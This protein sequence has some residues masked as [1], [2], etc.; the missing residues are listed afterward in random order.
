MYP[1]SCRHLENLI[2]EE[3]SFA[4]PR[5]GV[6][7]GSQSHVNHLL[8][9]LNQI[10]DMDAEDPEYR[11]KAGRWIGY[12]MGNLEHRMVL[13]NSQSRSLIT[14]DR[15]AEKTPL[16]VSKVFIPAAERREKCN[17]FPKCEGWEYWQIAGTN[18]RSCKAHEE[19]LAL[20]ALGS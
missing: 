15:L 7:D 20:G 10:R 18:L 2:H 16:P 5:Q 17:V 12:V 9:M 3:F 14:L 19:A 13:A 6:V 11:E 4:V 1:H 8:W